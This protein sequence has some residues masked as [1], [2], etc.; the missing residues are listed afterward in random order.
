MANYYK[1]KEVY[2]P[3]MEEKKKERENLKHVHI[4]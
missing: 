3:L 4:K 1:G 2:S